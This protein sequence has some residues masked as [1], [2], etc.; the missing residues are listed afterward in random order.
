MPTLLRVG[1]VLS[2][3]ERYEIE[4]VTPD[5]GILT[6]GIYAVSYKAR[7]QDGRFHLLK[8]YKEPLPT[9]RW[10]KAYIS[11]QQEIQK[12]LSKLG[13][14][15][16]QL[17]ETF[18]HSSGEYIQI[19]EWVDGKTLQDVRDEHV[20]DENIAQRL[21]L[22]KV[23]AY[24][25][26]ELH[27]A[28]IIHCDQKLANVFAARA[29]SLGLGWRVKINDFDWSILKDRKAPWPGAPK[30][31]PDYASPEHFRGES[32]T[33]A[34]D[35]YTVGG[36]MFFEL[37][38]GSHPYDPVIQEAEAIEQA[39][40]LM[41]QACKKGW[42][43]DFEEIDPAKAARV[44][45]NVKDAILA[46]LS[47]SPAER[48]SAEDLHKVLLG[49]PFPKSGT[50]VTSSPKPA[51]AVAS[52]PVSGTVT[53]AEVALRKIRE[54]K[55]L[56]SATSKLSASGPTILRLGLPG[57]KLAYP[58]SARTVLS[59]GSLERFFQVK[60]PGISS[61]QA[62]IEP[63]DDKREWFI[64]HREGAV[65]LTCVNGTLANG[66]VKLEDGMRVEVG[67]PSSGKIESSLVVSIL[68][69]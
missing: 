62:T 56:K 45:Q 65:N 22:C 25:L 6:D 64:T 1:E 14:S 18:V 17:E 47:W 69:L 49:A 4:P 67:N 29:P 68:P 58:I 28:G 37:L 2:G 19:I 15:V 12:R 11:Y 38:M 13:E 66:R 40:Q 35:I 36:I 60:F 9:D 10:F 41:M 63:S 57:T 54:G 39:V 55:S 52:A 24:G 42:K 30:G 27:R 48:P 61:N 33:E 7:G 31:T 8:V 20:S 44:P 23:V 3:R 46:C 59:R 43:P 21:N 50:A 51:T 53:P 32:P 16:I 34:S 26:I 5:S